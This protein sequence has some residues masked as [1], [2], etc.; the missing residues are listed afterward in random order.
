MLLNLL[1]NVFDA[2]HLL[3]ERWVEIEV[4]STEK[5]VSISVTDSGNGISPEVA[6]KIM[7]PFFTTKEIGKGTGLGLSISRGIIESHKGTLTLVTDFPNTRFIIELPLFQNV[8]EKSLK[9]G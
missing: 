4:F 8:L 5:Y 9:A 6:S 2:I 1:K 3:K 7:L